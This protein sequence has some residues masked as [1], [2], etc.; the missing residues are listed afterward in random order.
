MKIHEFSGSGFSW[1]VRL[2]CIIK[3]VDYEVVPIQPTPEAM[4]SPEFLKLSPRGKVPVLQDGGFTLTESMAAIAYI[5]RKVG[6]RSLFG[7]T[8]EAHGCIWRKVLDFDLYVAGTM[9]NGIILPV[10]LQ[11]T[12]SAA[13]AIRDAA[14]SSHEEL[15]ALEG[16]ITEAGWLEGDSISAADIAVY[17]IL[18]DAIRFAT[19]P[20]ARD[21]KLGFE[22]FGKHYPNLDAWRTAIQALPGYEKTYPDFWREVDAGGL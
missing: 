6:G 5:D 13:D 19:K 22:E 14:R 20:E 1:R 2:A 3:S 8:P 10:L 4:K 16:Q 21:L 12:E 9:V 11:Q 18:E 7:G 15:K 17:P